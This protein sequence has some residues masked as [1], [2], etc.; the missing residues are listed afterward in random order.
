MFYKFLAAFRSW[1]FDVRG[2]TALEYGLIVAGI[3]MA[4]I[5]TIFLT[6]TSLSSLFSAIA[7]SMSSSSSKIEAR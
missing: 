7:E 2:A 5:L 6:G 4:I 1:I 3:A